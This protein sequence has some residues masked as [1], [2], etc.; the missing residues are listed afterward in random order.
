MLMPFLVLLVI[1]AGGA[2]LEHAAPAER[3][4]LARNTIFNVA[5]GL[6]TGWLRL[7]LAPAIG[8]AVTFLINGVG[9]G[10]IRLPAHGWALVGS[11]VVYI[12]FID[13][14]EFAFHRAQHAVPFLWAMHSFHHSDPA[15]N[16]S[17]AVRNYWLEIPLKA[18][19]V[20]P[21]AAILFSVPS[22]VLSI[23]AVTTIWHAVNHLNVRWHVPIPW[24]IL[25]NP[26]FHRLHHSIHPEHY[27]KNF[28]PYFPL[29]DVL[30]GTAYV[31]APGEFPPT[32][33]AEEQEP[34]TFAD[35]VLW[36]WRHRL[37]NTR[38]ATANVTN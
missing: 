11:A 4:Q 24:F 23:Y 5:Y 26:Q 9:G 30:G 13:F 8:I 21:L 33:L 16:V 25:N 18:V 2:L 1:V 15:V 6:M 20:Y 32:G 34:I 38:A 14:L 12:L 37:R 10:W 36:P 19:F 27:N 7:A 3:N 22:A 28:S 17:T 31:P 35:A 29:W